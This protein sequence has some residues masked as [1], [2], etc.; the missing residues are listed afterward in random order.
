MKNLIVLAC[1]L[2]AG[3]YKPH[4]YYPEDSSCWIFTDRDSN[5]VTVMAKGQHLCCWYST[6]AGC[7]LWTEDKIEDAMI[8]WYSQI[9][10]ENP[11]CLLEE[12]N[13]GPS[14]EYGRVK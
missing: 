5:Y 11:E 4:C 13:C 7:R 2:I 3:C 6:F 8:Q 12:E 9:V 1:L 10:N 14:W